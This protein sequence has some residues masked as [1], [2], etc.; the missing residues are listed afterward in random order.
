M[1]ERAGSWCTEKTVPLASSRA[2]IMVGYVLCVDDSVQLPARI[3]KTG[4]ES[5]NARLWVGL[6][7]ISSACIPRWCTCVR[8][9][10]HRCYFYSIV[11]G[12]LGDDA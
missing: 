7:R 5:W 1:M 6:P 12:C 11:T 4:S 9:L 3:I 10:Y 2:V 8:A